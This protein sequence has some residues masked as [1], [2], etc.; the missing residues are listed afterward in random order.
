MLTLVTLVGML[1]YWAGFE[2]Y[3]DGKLR[4][5]LYTPG[6]EYGYVVTNREIY[7]DTV[8]EKSDFF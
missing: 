1:G 5:G 7:L 4:I 3:S 8:F 2:G 6:A